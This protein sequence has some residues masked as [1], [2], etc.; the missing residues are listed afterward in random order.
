MAK[1]G[2]ARVQGSIS[3]PGSLLLAIVTAILSAA[4][5]VLVLKF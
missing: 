3:M 2:K 5:L 4:V 1:L